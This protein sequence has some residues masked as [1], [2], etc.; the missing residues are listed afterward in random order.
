MKTHFLSI[1]TVYVWGSFFSVYAEDRS[2]ADYSV[3][4]DEV[5]AGG[6]A[7]ASADY[8]HQGALGALPAV[9]QS[10]D[11]GNRAGH[12][13]RLYEVTGRA[14]EMDPAVYEDTPAAIKTTQGSESWTLNLTVRD[15]NPDNYGSHAADGLPDAWQAQYFGLNNPDAAPGEDPDEDTQDNAFEFGAGLN[16][17]DAA[18]FFSFH[19][20]EDPGNP[21]RMQVV[22]SPRWGDRSYVVKSTAALG[23]SADWQPLTGGDFAVEDQGDE[24]SVTDLRVLPD[25]QFYQI[26]ITTD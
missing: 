7:S 21:G 15:V 12:V 10:A 8:S 11:Y 17:N 18:S 5:N 26:E 1:L 4:S 9:T 16:P 19:I 14:L 13:A 23:P 6:G 25:Q 2:S 20:Q 24:R 22:F 3:Q